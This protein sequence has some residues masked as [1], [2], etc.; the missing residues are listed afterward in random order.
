MIVAFDVVIG[1]GGFTDD[2]T[3]TANAGGSPHSQLRADDRGMLHPLGR[4]VRPT[5]QQTTRSA[6]PGRDPVVAV[7][8]AQGKAGQALDLYSGR[9]RAPLLLPEHAAPE[10]R[11]RPDSFAPL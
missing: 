7:I 8:P 6:R 2:C 3:Q 5:L 10:N 9:L 4:R 1:D 11:D